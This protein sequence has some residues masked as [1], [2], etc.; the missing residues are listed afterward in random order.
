LQGP[1]SV[2]VFAIPIMGR[3]RSSSENPMAF[4]IA[5]AGALLGPSVIAAL[6]FF[7]SFIGY[8]LWRNRSETLEAIIVAG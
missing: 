1:I 7:S 4:N 2:Q 3:R 6:C 5:R 8:K